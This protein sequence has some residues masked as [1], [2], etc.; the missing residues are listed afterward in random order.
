[1]NKPT[2]SNVAISPDLD[3]ETKNFILLLRTVANGI[4]EA[5]IHEGK[6]TKTIIRFPDCI[7]RQ[8]LG[9]YALTSDERNI[10]STIRF[11]KY[12]RVVVNIN[13]MG[14]YVIMGDSY[15]QF[16][17]SKEIDWADWC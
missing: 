7:N 17:C 1:M 16:D 2:P 3:K 15:Q 12:G 6:P 5:A 8:K 4:I 11:L 9:V 10:I 14:R 13:E